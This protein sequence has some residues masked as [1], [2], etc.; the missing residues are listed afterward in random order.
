MSGLLS[1]LGS[2]ANSVAS[3]AAGGLSGVVAMSALIATGVV[4]VGP[5]PA[6]PQSLALVG[7][8]G[9]GSIVAVAQPGDKMLV[10]GRSAD[11]A[12]LRVYV[13][14][15]ASD[16]WVPASALNL[17]ADGSTLPVAGCVEAA[18]V[19]LTA[20]PATVTPTVPPTATPTPTATARPTATPTAR[21]TATP[22]QIPTATPNP[23]P[24]LG[25]LTAS[26][27]TLRYPV[28]VSGITCN[29]GPTSTRISVSAKDAQ[30]IGSVTLWY[31]KPGASS[32]TSRTMVHGS[33]ST[34]AATLSV[35][36]DGLTAAGSLTYYVVAKDGSPEAATT[37]IPAGT[38][39]IAV[40]ACNLPPAFSD[41]GSESPLFVPTVSSGCPVGAQTSIN[42][43]IYVYDPDDAVTKVT[44]YYR[45]YGSSSWY[46][47]SLKLAFGGYTSRWDG[48]LSN[49]NFPTLPTYGTFDA[50]W[51]VRMTDA[52]GMVGTS[53]VMTLAEEGCVILY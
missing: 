17:L 4:A 5:P 50:S 13:P 48:V 7:C 8:P 49:A 31:R 18:V 27:T 33:G 32:Y 11:G 3:L 2:G 44:F 16:G 34:Y 43:R 14:G 20:V 30:G 26:N 9:S 21:P 22:A 52:G 12:W 35:A 40:K 41:T 24:T 45:P 6:G 53:S 1:P 19:P 37:R 38:K 47:L 42:I 25:N 39:S 28:V 51:Y 36:A 23:G 46:A 10:T 29:T 15:P